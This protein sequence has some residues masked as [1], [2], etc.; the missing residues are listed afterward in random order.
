M[1]KA[2][3]GASKRGGDDVGFLRSEVSRLESDLKRRQENYILRERAHLTKIEE[4]EE[5]IQNFKKAKAGWMD[6]D[7]KT[8]KLK[9]YQQQILDNVELVQERTGKILQE[10]E[11]DLLRAFRARLFD[12]Q[13][14]LERE[15]NKKDEGADVWVE[16][17]RQLE[18]E[19]EW[20]KEVSDRLERINQSLTLE[21]N[22]LKSQYKSQEDDRNFMIKELV[23]VKKENAK[24]K[25]EFTALEQENQQMRDKIKHL[26]DSNT[27]RELLAD[28]NTKHKVDNN[29]EERYKELNGRLQ[30]MLNEER[31]HLH[32]VRQ[33]Y[34]LELK[35]RTEMELLLRQC[36]DDVRKDISKT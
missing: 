30:R 34:A 28:V 16:R 4:L 1:N 15:R 20:S 27:K 10:Q 23:M 8:H 35:S 12:I 33:N 19:L 6:S 3:L 9:A 22:R 14:E 2:T 31:K 18:A 7:D 17:G 13:S 29:S 32:Q 11:R 36:V 26:E 25:V 5:E 24:F 21:N